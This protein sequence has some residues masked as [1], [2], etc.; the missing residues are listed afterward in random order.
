MEIAVSPELEAIIRY[1][2]DE[3]MRTGHYGIGVDHLMLGLLRHGNNDACTAIRELGGDSVEFK[4]FLDDRLFRDSQIP[5]FDEDKMGFTKS[6]D[7]TL[8]IAVYES[9][10]WGQPSTCPEHLLLAI[11]R[12]EKSGSR[13]YLDSKGINHG[14]LTEFFRRRGSLSA[15]PDP[16]LPKADEIA[17]A[18]EQEL[19]R[20]IAYI[21][22]RTSDI[23]S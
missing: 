16:V 21:P 10:K 11:C 2:R 19:R 23:Y 14:I 5:F 6:A 13:E 1:A 4:R 22:I 18:L 12:N 15:V 3:A 17:T 9:L 20:L 8:N 7:S